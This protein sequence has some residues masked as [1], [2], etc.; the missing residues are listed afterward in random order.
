MGGQGGTGSRL[1]VDWE[2]ERA[3]KEFRT[4]HGQRYGTGRPAMRAEQAGRLP[5]WPIPLDPPLER[6]PVSAQCCQAGMKAGWEPRS[7]MS[8]N[9]HA[10]NTAAQLT[11]AAG[12]RGGRKP[13][14]ACPK[15]AVRCAELG[16]NLKTNAESQAGPLCSGSA[17]SAAVER[18]S[19]V[20][21]GHQ[22]ACRSQ[23]HKAW[24]GPG[25]C[26]PG[27]P[28]Q[29][30]LHA[31]LG[32]GNGGL[33]RHS[34][35]ALASVVR[36]IQGMHI[37]RPNRHM[38]A[39]L[40]SARLLHPLQLDWVIA[41]SQPHAQSLGLNRGCTCRMGPRRGQGWAK[42]GPRM[43]QGGATQGTRLGR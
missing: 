24:G 17:T 34:S 29:L 19:G 3:Q 13:A 18:G 15:A 35:N 42:D 16:D 2:V 22:T 10:S 23:R 21:G 40:G 6:K 5:A 33:R 31:K 20:L 27:A 11:A 4:S 25:E 41:C 39:H 43:G 8:M 26:R 30:D 32:E 12:L 14:A 37:I 28:Q 38:R 36:T 7:R 1:G 9:Q